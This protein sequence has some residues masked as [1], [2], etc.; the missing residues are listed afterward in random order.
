MAFAS[1]SSITPKPVTAIES[2]SSCNL[3]LD[4]GHQ[5]SLMLSRHAQHADSEQHAEQHD[6]NAH[7]LPPLQSSLQTVYGITTTDTN[8][9]S[10]FPSSCST[11][12]VSHAA[13]RSLDDVKNDGP[14]PSSALP[15]AV[16]PQSSPLTDNNFHASV[17]SKIEV[18]SSHPINHVVRSSILH[19]KR[20]NPAIVLQNCGSVARDHLASERTFLAYVHTSLSLSSAG[21]GVVQ[22]LTI[23]DL[24]FPISSEIPIMDA[25]KKMKK[26]AMPLGVLTQVLALYILFLGESFLLQRQVS[27]TVKVWA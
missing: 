8:L 19:L 7:P 20:F 27:S 23:T 9:S 22:L 3:D 18:S 1:P 17:T 11:P 14:Y 2:N 16:E 10:T 4:T 15:P 5:K 25:S 13:S 6:D 24:I 26:F 21:V 12:N